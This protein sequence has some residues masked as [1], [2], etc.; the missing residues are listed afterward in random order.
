MKKL[1]I[2]LLIISVLMTACQPKIG[3]CAGV[4][5]EYVQEC[6]DNQA[7]YKPNCIGQWEIE[8]G[9]CRFICEGVE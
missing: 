2:T 7:E 6:C 5:P 4:A 9:E 8:E 3:G 1:I